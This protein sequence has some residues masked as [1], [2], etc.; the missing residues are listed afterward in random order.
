MALPHPLSVLLE[1]LGAVPGLAPVLLTVLLVSTV[2]TVL[3]AGGGR[4]S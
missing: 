3:A 1:R 4:W 2:V